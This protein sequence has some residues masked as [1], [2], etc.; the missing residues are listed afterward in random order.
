M[1]KSIILINPPTKYWNACTPVG[2]ASIAAYLRREGHDVR[3]IDAPAEGFGLE[4]LM[5]IILFNR[6]DYVGI[7][8]M[9]HQIKNAY[10]LVKE[11]KSYPDLPTKVIIGGTHA[12]LF[13]KE[14]L[15]NGADY[16]II[17]EGEL[18]MAELLAGRR[19][20]EID[21]LG[22]KDGSGV[23]IN[24]ERA[25]IPDLNVLPEPAR[26]LLPMEKYTEEKIFGNVALEVMFSRG[27]PYNCVFCSS[28]KLWKRRVRSRS[29]PNMIA[30]LQHLV[31]DYGIRYFMLN[32][33]SFTI[34]KKFVSE[35]C[36]A[37][38]DSGLKIKWSCLTRVNIVDEEM[39]QDMKSAGCVRVS[40][41][42]ESGNQDVLDFVHKYTNLD[43]IRKAVKMTKRVG[44]PAVLL[45]I[46][47]HPTET[48]AKARDSI[49]FMKE[50]DPF[51]YGF[52]MMVPFIGTELGDSIAEKTGTIVTK[53]WEE[54][55]TGVKPIFVP[56][57]LTPETIYALFVEANM[58]NST[59]RKAL[60]RIVWGIQMVGL[61]GLNRHVLVTEGK[62]VALWFLYK[63]LGSK[64]FIEWRKRR[65]ESKK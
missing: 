24:K 16:V 61:E 12:T 36:R 17:G 2:L 46:V 11:I 51:A 57:D 52:Q 49:A 26:D 39:L 15:E 41:G 59:P 40:Y 25:F 44:I 4:K 20:E 22:W 30:E 45:M 29:V 60:R 32:D 23:R 63:V 33:D 13:P 53:N 27:C 6:P 62:G 56:K 10:A 47:G 48:E 1:K 8:G 5:R 58:G 64:R 34:N 54:Y 14:A 9:S 65:L 3:I 43:M 37:V 28:P 42:V 21:G 18:T 55:V 7:T 31:I 19:P 50:L 35:F 38:R